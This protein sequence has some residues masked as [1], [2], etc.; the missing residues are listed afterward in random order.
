MY[1]A[2]IFVYVRIQPIVNYEVPGAVVVSKRRR[3]PPIL[4]KV[5]NI[6]CN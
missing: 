1:Q 5:I 3:V 6:L 4:N 2:D